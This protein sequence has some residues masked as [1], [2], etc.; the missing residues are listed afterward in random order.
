MNVDEK[1]VELLDKKV[2]LLEEYVKILEQKVN[3]LEEQLK[4]KNVVVVNEEDMKRTGFHG[5]NWR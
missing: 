4:R 3:I 2:N 1:Y 5:I